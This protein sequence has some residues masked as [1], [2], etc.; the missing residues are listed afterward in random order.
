MI[1]KDGLSKS[2][3][4]EQFLKA[5]YAHN[6][7][8]ILEGQSSAMLRTFATANCLIYLEAHKTI[9]AGSEVEVLIIR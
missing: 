2:I 9:T 6:E 7:V 1:C 5:K 3:S 4:R 8:E